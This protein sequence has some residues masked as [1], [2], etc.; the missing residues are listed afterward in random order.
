ME[1]DVAILGA[2]SAGYAAASSAQSEGAS[3]A[4][5]D[6]GPLGGLCILNG[7]MPTKTI[8]RSSDIISLMRRAEEFGLSPI[9]VKANL[10]AINDRKN[11]LIGEFA[12]YRI[13]QLKN[14]RF[15]LIEEKAEFISISS[16]VAFTENQFQF[17]ANSNVSS[18][19]PPLKTISNAFSRVRFV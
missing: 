19:V 9:E 2:G 16:C 3:V 5:V 8:I 17:G 11:Q 1:F 15:T 18:T 14:S 12:N 6:P 13:E 10:A 7:C 4:I